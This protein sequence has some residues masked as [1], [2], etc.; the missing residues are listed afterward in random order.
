MRLTTARY[1]TPSGRSIQALGIEPE[2]VVQPAKLEKIALGHG[3][4]EADLKG[5]LQNDTVKP[6]AKDKDKAGAQTPTGAQDDDSLDTG[7]PSDDKS[8]DDKKAS[9]KDE[10]PYDYQLARA[11]DL[12]HGVYVF[13]GKK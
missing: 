6:D 11:L 5:A 13:G 7:L 10:K 2:I 8:K 3:I 1:Y 12:V 9:A 4:H